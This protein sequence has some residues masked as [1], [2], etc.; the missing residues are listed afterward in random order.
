MSQKIALAW[1]HQK[2]TRSLHC[3]GGILADDQVSSLDSSG[4]LDLA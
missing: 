4:P 1:M 2:E 3:L